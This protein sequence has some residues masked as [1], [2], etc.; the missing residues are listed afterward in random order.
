M[1]ALTELNR[2]DYLILCIL[3][4]YGA[5]SHFTGATISEIMESEM[6]SARVTIYQ[7]LRRLIRLGYIKKG[8][9]DIKADTYHLTEKGVSITELEGKENDKR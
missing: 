7:K 1:D 3:K 5:T 6:T 4:K 8:V 2:L 9:K